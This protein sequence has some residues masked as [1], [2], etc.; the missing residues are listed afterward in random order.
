MWFVGIYQT[1]SGQGD[2]RWR[3]LAS[4]GW[5]ALAATAV[6]ALL[7]SLVSYRRVLGTTLEAVLASLF[8]IAVVSVAELVTLLLGSLRGSVSLAVVG[9]GVIA[10]LRWRGNRALSASGGLAFEHEESG[11]QAL[12]LG[13]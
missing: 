4:R 5:I 12:G 6:V 9:L 10:W 11:T 8:T 7:A 13:A 3:L 2:G 1:V